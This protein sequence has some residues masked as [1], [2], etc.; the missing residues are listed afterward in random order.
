M[1]ELKISKTFTNK[2]FWV[3]FKG[4]FPQPGGAT[5][6]YSKVNGC[7]K[8]SKIVDLGPDLLQKIKKKKK[9]D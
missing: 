1:E 7:N 3:L 4:V 6:P 8:P 5:F 9:K 2:V